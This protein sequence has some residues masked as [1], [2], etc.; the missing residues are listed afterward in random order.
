GRQVARRSPSGIRLG[1]L[2]ARLYAMAL[3]TGAA[4]ETKMRWPVRF[5][6]RRAGAS[7]FF[8][9]SSFAVMLALALALVPFA[10]ESALQSTRLDWGSKAAMPTARLFH[11][12]AA[13]PNGKLYAV[14]GYNIASVAAGGCGG[15]CKT[16]E[17]Y[18]PATNSWAPRAALAT[19]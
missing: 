3:P 5:A 16:V 4:E 6:G 12:L 8:P 17:E 19:A 9:R 7:T 1:M 10:G 11:G 13:A 14:G 15:E 18:D 2:R